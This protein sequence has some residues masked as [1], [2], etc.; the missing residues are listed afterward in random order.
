MRKGTGTKWLVKIER[1]N[2]KTTGD[3]SINLKLTSLAIP[4]G[5]MCINGW[6]GEVTV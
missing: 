3:D 5:W 2:R 4:E 6:M 1:R